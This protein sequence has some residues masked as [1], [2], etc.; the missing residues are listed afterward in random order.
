MLEPLL[1]IRRALSLQVGDA[2]K[3][4]A[5]KVIA[6]D[7]RSLQFMNSG[8]EVA[9]IEIDASKDVLRT[10]LPRICNKQGRNQFSGLVDIARVEP[11]NGSVGGGVGVPSREHKGFVKFACSLLEARFGGREIG[12]LS[13]AERD[14]FI[15]AAL[16]LL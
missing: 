5:L 9:T 6:K 14:D 8:F 16:G 11:G 13:Q 15:V 12:E 7:Y 4:R 2:E 3:V 1:G 10:R